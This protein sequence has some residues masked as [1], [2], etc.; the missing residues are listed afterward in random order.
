VEIPSYALDPELPRKA[1][2]MVD[3]LTQSSPAGGGSRSSA[4]VLGLV[5]AVV[6][7]LVGWLVF[8]RE[9]GD[10]NVDVDLPRVEA[11]EADAPTV[12]VKVPEKVDVNVKTN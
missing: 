2:L 4:W 10:G 9:S 5:A 3:E 8:G 11:P 1:P 7:L 6:L 12:E